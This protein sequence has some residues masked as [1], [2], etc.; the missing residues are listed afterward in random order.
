[1]EET[2]G[3][4]AAVDGSREVASSGKDAER[5]GIRGFRLIDASGFV[6]DSYCLVDYANFMAACLHPWPETAASGIFPGPGS[7]SARSVGGDQ[8]GGRVAVNDPLKR[9]DDH[10]GDTPDGNEDGPLMA[11]IATG[12]AEAFAA[13]YD[14]H[15]SLF[16]GLVC[17]ILGDEQEAEDV[18]Q[19]ACVSLWERA[20]Q[21]DASLGRPL[22]WATTIVRNRAIDRHRARIRRSAVFAPV[23]E[24]GELPAPPEEL[25]APPAT[26]LADTATLVRRTLL[27]LPGAQRAALEMAYFGGL[28]H[29]EISQQLA[30]PLGTIKA[31]IRRGLLALRDTLEGCL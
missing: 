18:V 20:P 12:D 4:V 3:K 11:R 26:D 30:V 8:P 24:A 27:H 28:T 31:R 22:S 21:Y 25:R 17:R 7:G 1:M 23:D 10:V 13:F 15:S 14:R 29:L 6:A 9:S 16:F 2:S 5:E 19:E